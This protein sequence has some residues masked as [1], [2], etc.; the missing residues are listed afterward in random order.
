MNEFKPPLEEIRFALRVWAGLPVLMAGKASGAADGETIEAIV[1]EAG[2]FA[3]E[4]LAPL[5]A[6]GHREGCSLL[7]DGSVRTPSGWVQAYA[8]FVETGWNTVHFPARLGGQG[9]PAPVSI[10]VAELFEAAN[11][12]FNLAL[13]P[14]AGVVSLLD[15]FGSP[16]QKRRYLA[17][18]VSGRWSATLAMTEPQAGTD[19]GAVRTKATEVTE[20]VRID[21]QKC[22]ISY[23]DHEMN[24]NIIHFV[25]A[26]DPSGK[27]GVKGLSL[28]VVPKRLVQGDGTIGEQN[29]VRCIA[30]EK[31]MG[32]HGSPTTVMQFGGGSPGAWGERLGEPCKGLEQ[33]FVVLNRARLNIGVFG[34]ASAE[35]ASQAAEAYAHERVQ[36]VDADGQPCV[37]ARHPDVRRMLLEMRCG[38]DSIR[39]VAYYAAG[40]L[41]RSQHPADADAAAKARRRLD[42]LTPIVKGW[43]T[44]LAFEVASTGVQVAGGIGFM[45]ESV[46]ARCFLDARVHPIYEGTT[47]I[48][49]M[50]L[51]MRKV[52][53]DGGEAAREL[54]AEMRA[55]WPGHLRDSGLDDLR[56]DVDRALRSVSSATECLVQRAASAPAEVQAVGVPYL[57][58]WG[59]A[60]S[61]WLLTAAAA[62]AEDP[63]RSRRARFAIL[64]RL[65]R[66]QAYLHTVERG[67]AVVL[68]V[69]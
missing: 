47:G 57:W 55:T 14:F 17:P 32:I 68:D 34:L 53:R 64:H 7:P 3:A 40:L 10:A 13:M 23:G 19:I 6:V 12:A 51:A 60:F 42:F 52:A 9:L 58:M 21:G 63:A 36:G 45:D 4:V 56:G 30:V 38:V 24:E 49:A 46:A 44:E 20:G 43:G 31:K 48:Q 35:R 37:I 18:L 62:A 41:E 65:P 25:L 33:M 69:E 16:D 22:F 27:P 1:S 54:L 8:K 39:A 67:G 28:Y 66:V 11:V 29:D 15:R 50:D 5:D 59:T 61:A 2:R 26:R